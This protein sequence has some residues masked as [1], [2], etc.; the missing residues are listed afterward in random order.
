MTL[1]KQGIYKFQIS[2][3]DCN[4]VSKTGNKNIKLIF[5]IIENN[6]VSHQIFDYMTKKLDPKTN[7][8]FIFVVKKIDG[9]LKSIGKPELFGKPLREEDFKGA[10]G[11]A[12][13]KLEKAN[14]IYGESNKID[15]FISID[16]AKKSFILN[17]GVDECK[18][19][20][21]PINSNGNVDNVDAS[22][23]GDDSAPITDD[24]DIPF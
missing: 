22:F 15:R 8:R 7:K 20:S 13:V 2:Y 1:L 18:Q 10:E 21:T 24:S 16:E 19:T 9:L 3:C 17:A 14:G 6:G 23:F 5:D 11:H 4:F 12:Y